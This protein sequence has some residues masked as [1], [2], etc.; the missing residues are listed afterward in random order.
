MMTSGTRELYRSS[1]GDQWHLVRETDSGRVLIKHQ[2]NTASG[3]RTSYVEIAEFFTDGHGPEHQALLQLIG[4]LVAEPVIA[5][6]E[7]RLAE[8]DEQRARIKANPER[9]VVRERLRVKR[10]K[11]EKSDA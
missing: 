5:K 10:T 1:N 6:A 11:K 2:P 3:G 4:T 9:E 8:A 7:R